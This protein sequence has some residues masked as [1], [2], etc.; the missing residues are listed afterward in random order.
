M[1]HYLTVVIL[2]ALFLLVMGIVGGIETG[3]IT[4][5]GLL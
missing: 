4:L 2:G 5:G 3:T 1:R